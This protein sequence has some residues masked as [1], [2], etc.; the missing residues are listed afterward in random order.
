MGYIS[1][2]K[3]YY[4]FFLVLF[5]LFFF[6]SPSAAHAYT[7]S[8]SAAVVIGQKDFISS[9]ANQGGSTSA[10]SM[11]SPSAA[12]IVGSQLLVADAVNNRILVYNSIPSVNNQAADVVIGQP[13][14]T[15]KTSGCTQ[16]KFNLG[17]GGIFY[18]G[19]KLFVA[20]A[21]NNRVLV[22]NGIPTQNGPSANYVLGQSSFTTCTAN[23][24]GVSA[25]SLSNP[26]DVTSDGAKLYIA[27]AGNNRVLGYLNFPSTSALPADFVIGQPDTST[28]TVNTGGVN[29]NTLSN[30]RGITIDNGSLLISDTNNYRVLIFLSEPTST[31]IF[32][33]VVLGQTSFTANTSATISAQSLQPLRITTDATSSNGI[34]YV[35]DIQAN[36]V[37][38]FN[39]IPFNNATAANI[40]IGQQN[41]TSSSAN[42]GGIGPATMSSPKGAFSNHTQLAVADSLNN[43][44]LIYQNNLQNPS[45]S[46]ANNLTTNP[47]DTIIINGTATAPSPYTVADVQYAANGDSWQESTP[48]NG[49]FRLN[50]EPFTLAFDPLANS[51]S[52]PGYTVVVRALD[53]NGDS[54]PYA[55]FFSPFTLNAPYD[56]SDVDTPYPSFDFS[57]NTQRAHMRDNL[58]K[59]QVWV[60]QAGTS[61][62]KL[63][64]DNIPPD[65]ASVSTNLENSMRNQYL[66]NA[67]NNGTYDTTG[68]RAKYDQESSHIVVYAK[69]SSET[70]FATGGKALSGTYAWKVVAV[71]KSGHSLGSDSLYVRVN[72]YQ[73]VDNQALFPL[74]ILNITGIGDPSISSLQPDQIQT[75]Y[76]TSVSSPTFYG[77]AANQSTV[78]LTLTNEDCTNTDPEQ[79]S[80]PYTTVTN[81]QSRFGI[82]LPPNTLLPNTPYVVD[83]NAQLI[84][85]YVELPSF[86]LTYT[87]YVAS[88]L[89]ANGQEGMK[90]NPIINQYVYPYTKTRRPVTLVPLNFLFVS[91]MKTS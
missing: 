23:S 22:F 86:T 65:F 80:E 3:I 50:T 72:S 69:E 68:F 87:P 66:S 58:Q 11:S 20:D 35:S 91:F 89:Q 57:V 2:Q 41:F 63:Y 34:F 13:D 59:Y 78:T 10:Q 14:F 37:L 25:R 70:P 28:V 60:R 79:C 12:L 26:A 61:S 83:M 56:N 24:G 8:A 53:T 45:V 21:N 5:F 51:N 77:I 4:V 67:T 88:K 73:T 75:D 19:G 36:R 29:G 17:D 52:T 64:L 85:N 30:P 84:R 32:A 31:N 71:D 38:A 74:T 18:T 43:R 6:L 46:V 48:V 15:T 40:V 90:Q 82:N 76:T 39:A 42:A 9:Q 27:D 62:W 44:V 47:D 7:S 1:Y 49:A 55:F 54:S 81:P 16:S 33:D